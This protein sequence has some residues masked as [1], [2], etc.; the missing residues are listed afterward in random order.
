MVIKAKHLKT[1][2]E[3]NK[4]LLGEKKALNIFFQTRWG[5]HTFFMKF[6]I[7][8]IILDDEFRVAGLKE[9]LKPN[10]VFFWN[11]KYS[12]VLELPNG[13]ARKNK[14]KVEDLIKLDLF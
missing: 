10:R 5:I 8:V 6:P 14:I 7:D 4:G 1:L 13:F 2:S 3:K 11:L 12:N 9:N